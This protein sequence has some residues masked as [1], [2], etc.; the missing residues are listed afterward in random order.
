MKSLA[1]VIV[2]LP[3]VAGATGEEVD[4][5]PNWEERVMHEWTNR[6][7]C[8]PQVEMTAC[9]TACGEADCYAPNP[10][11]P[12][13]EDLNHAA[14]FHSDEMAAQDYFDHD[15][16]CQVVSNIDALY[17]DSCMGAASC[18]CTTGSPTAWSARVAL[19]GGS[20]TGE[21][22]ASYTDPDTAF[23]QWL[24]ESYPYTGCAYD[25]GPPTNGHRW[26]LLEGGPS[27]G[28]G[29]GSG[30]SV[31]DLGGGGTQAKIPSGSH[32]PR[33]AASVQAWANWYD[34][35]GP[36]AALV[37]VDGTCIPM[38]LERGSETNG[39]YK[40][41]VPGVGSGCHRY[42]FLFKDSTGTAVL[43]P[44]T[45]SLGIGPKG[46]CAD[47]DA[48][49]PEGSTNC[50]YIPPDDGSDGGGSGGGGDDAGVDNPE[51][52]DSSGGCCDT[53]SRG[54]GATALWLALAVLS[55]SSRRRLP[56]RHRS[57]SSR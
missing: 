39:A 41:D 27:I 26:N 19:F 57:Q 46:S 13:N 54:D 33:Q 45:G 34:S 29:H 3:A 17:P 7:R 11:L 9:G 5:F 36:Q 2:L 15:S 12:W 35:A 23:Y 25:Q 22:I 37:N 44:T 16:K 20:A 10:P 18:A 42:Y 31:G 48:S 52:G 32:Y 21:I 38:T 49:R 28:F 1:A 51:T 4:G 43:Y 14:R 47:W 8:D 55:I 40:A 56:R 30:Q 6:A 24:F 53:G 50:D